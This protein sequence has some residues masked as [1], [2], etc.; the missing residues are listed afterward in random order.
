ML[1]WGGAI[2]VEFT[3]IAAVA[4]NTAI[5]VESAILV[6]VGYAVGALV[7]AYTVVSLT[8]AFLIDD[9]DSK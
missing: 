2:A 8:L 1:V 5:G 3:C 6:V 7:F 4:S 9:Q